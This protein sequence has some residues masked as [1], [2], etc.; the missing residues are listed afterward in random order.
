MKQFSILH[1]IQQ[2][3]AGENTPVQQGGRRVRCTF[4]I[5]ISKYSKQACSSTIKQVNTASWQKVNLPCCRATGHPFSTWWQ[6]GWGDRQSEQVA[7]VC[8]CQRC[9]FNGVG[10]VLYLMKLAIQKKAGLDEILTRAGST[11]KGTHPHLSRSLYHFFFFFK[12]KKNQ[13]YMPHP[14]TTLY[15]MLNNEKGLA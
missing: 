5:Q 14:S 2:Y 9:K 10:N 4:S 6:V 15:S 3:Q 13:P 8:I 12:E 7:P 1:Y 11:V